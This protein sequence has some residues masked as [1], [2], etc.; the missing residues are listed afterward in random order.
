M[1][2]GLPKIEI[3]TNVEL[4]E[5]VKMSELTKLKQQVE[6]MQAEIERL[7]AEEREP[8]IPVG[9]LCWFWDGA[10]DDKRLSLYDGCTDMPSMPI[11]WDADDSYWQNSRI[12]N[13]IPGVMIWEKHDGGPCPVDEDVLVV[14]EYVSGACNALRAENVS[15]EAITAYAIIN[16]AEWM[17]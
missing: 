7:E 13:D 3:V 15:W 2:Y 16:K 9:T 17:E 6:E 14:A 11:E 1:S 4:K 12:A 10:D 5:I 8:A